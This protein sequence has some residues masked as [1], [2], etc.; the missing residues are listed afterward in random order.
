VNNP[1]I[2]AKLYAVL[3]HLMQDPVID[4]FYLVGGTALALHLEHR[5][6]VD[7]DLFTNSDF[8]SSALVSHFEKEYAAEQIAWEANT[9]RAHI[10]G[11]K[12]ELLTHQYPLLDEIKVIDDVRVVS[13]KD[14]AA[15]KLNAISGRGSKKDFW[16]L[17]ALLAHF[18]LIEM[19]DFFKAKYAANGI[20]HLIRSLSYYDDAETELTEIIDY[21]GKD[22]SAVKENIMK[23]LQDSGIQT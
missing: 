8:D 9:F 14:L 22:W 16:D 12:I 23:A 19:I 6:S 3:K 5:D 15:F 18:F 21:Q 2:S 17:D 20:W 11:I 13:L 7:I 1:A 10:Q 4:S